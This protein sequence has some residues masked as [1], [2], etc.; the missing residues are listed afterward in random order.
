MQRR[1]E[2]G[3]EVWRAGGAP[4]CSGTDAS[5]GSVRDENK[6]ADADAHRRA[7]G[8]FEGITGGRKH[9]YSFVLLRTHIFFFFRRQSLDSRQQPKKREKTAQ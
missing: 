6:S 1:W 8:Y 3:V 7:R 9:R 5:G 2:G 4:R